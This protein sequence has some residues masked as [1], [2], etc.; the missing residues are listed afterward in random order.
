MPYISGQDAE[1]D[2]V[3]S[4]I[5]DKQTATI[6]KD[7]RELAKV[8]VQMAN[9]ILTGSAPVVNNTT[10]YN[11][12][13]EVIPTYLLTPLEITKANYQTLLVEGGY[14]STTEINSK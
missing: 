2:S 12:G 7:S 4:I 10:S 11:N 5:A 1:L 3:K 14:Y 6:F 8:A 13:V 9:A